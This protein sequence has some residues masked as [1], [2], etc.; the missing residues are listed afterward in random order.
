MASKLPLAPRQLLPKADPESSSASPV[1]DPIPVA[2]GDQPAKRRCISSACMP[3]RKRKSKC[4]GGKPACTACLDVY[5]SECH[6]DL[7]A[8]HRRKGA[9]KRDINHLSE[10]VS[11]IGSVLDAIRSGSEADADDIFQL[12]RA[13]PGESHE[14][15]AEMVR[16]MVKNRTSDQPS[17]EPPSSLEGQL[18][19][20]FHGKASMDKTGLSTHYGH[21][22]HFLL[23]APEE[24]RLMTAEQVG[25]W[26][27]VTADSEL[28]NHLLEAYFSWS[29]PLYLLF[30]E[31]L[32]YHGMRDNKP[33]YCTPLLVNSILAIGCHWSDRVEARADP[34]DPSTTGDHFFAEAKRLLAQNDNTTSLTIVQALGL[35]SLRQAMNNHDSS[36]RRY[37]AQMMSMAVELGLHLSSSAPAGGNFTPS[38]IAARRVT[39]WG[40]FVLETIWAV[41]VGRL[42]TIPRTAIRLERPTL[43]PKLENTPWKP[44]GRSEP[45]LTRLTQPSMKYTFLQQCSILIEIL[46]DILRSFYAPRDRITSRKLQLYHEQL[47]GWYRNLPPGFNIHKGRP[48]L[49]QVITLH[50]FYHNCIIMLFRPFVKVAFVQTSSETPRQICIAS[51]NTISQLLDLHKKT[52]G[53][54]KSFFVNT[55]CVMSTAI[56]HLINISSHPGVP[57]P[58][59]ETY[60][61][62]AIRAMHDMMK[63]TII[64]GRYLKIMRNMIYK[65][66]KVIPATV[67]AAME[68]ANIGTPHSAISPTTSSPETS[69]PNAFYHP[70]DPNGQNRNHNIDTTLTLN[71]KQSAPEILLTL[72]ETDSH[73]L[74]NGGGNTPKPQGGGQNLFWTPYPG[75]FEGVPLALPQQMNGNGH[76]DITS[77]LDSGV[78]GNWPQWNRDGFML[79]EEDGGGGGWG[80]DWEGGG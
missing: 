64:V 17:V 3:C 77:V 74:M 34:N 18:L 7:D 62:D 38:E 25:A 65:W 10:K 71:R 55:H 66:C 4:D 44:H 27:N 35:M 48:T 47:R 69:N 75:S 68:E 6:Y 57:N 80:F 2:G 61:A 31:E 5:S 12:I 59:V 36:G 32:F 13:S 73:D 19:M 56:I 24:E 49:P 52:Y 50:M 46:D 20:D 60:L 14:K 33:K 8:D 43:N 76:M 39:F 70:S 40:C 53:I 29:H 22:S 72:P 79:G 41:C 54:R 1:L 15:I 16:K 58:E 28:I 9:L 63:G 67:M 23:Q 42:T 26:T 45:D 51:A 78:M 11:T 30:S 21:T 37:V